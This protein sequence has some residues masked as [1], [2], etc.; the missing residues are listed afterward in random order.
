MTDRELRETTRLG[1]SR[2]RVGYRPE[3]GAARVYHEQEAPEGWHVHRHGT[4]RYVMST[5]FGKDEEGRDVR[6]QLI[7]I[8]DD[9]SDPMVIVDWLNYYEERID[10]EQ[11]TLAE[12][13]DRRMI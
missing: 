13:L 5:G 2:V 12:Y 6:G 9:A 4:G 1:P 8:F 3:D 7:H 10:R 11:M